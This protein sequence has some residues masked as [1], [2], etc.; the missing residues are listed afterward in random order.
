LCDDHL[1]TF[2]LFLCWSHTWH[3]KTVCYLSLLLMCHYVVSI[4]W[5]K[6]K[7]HKKDNCI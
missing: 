7:L 1:Q 4:L 3:K 5:Q 2:L 6:Y